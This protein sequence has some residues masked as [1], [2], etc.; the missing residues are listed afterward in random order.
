[1]LKKLNLGGFVM[2]SLFTTVPL[3]VMAPLF[4]AKDANFDLLSTATQTKN[5]ALTT[6]GTWAEFTL[7]NM[8]QKF[9]QEK[10]AWVGS[11]IFKSK[12]ALELKE[13]NLQWVGEN[14]PKLHASLY[15]KKIF[16]KKVIPIQENLVCDGTWN[17][18]K[19]QLIF[20]LNEK[21]VAINK[22]CL[23]LSFPKE[24]ESKIKNG[25]F[26]LAQENP[27]TILELK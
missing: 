6:T 23:V 13:V 11:I 26:L 9:K 4:T 24:F 14:I 10:W 17:K 21:I 5:F 7:K 19:Q 2:L 22:Y 3:L 25:R 16:D 8:Q 20:R 27:L 18:Q 15:Q 1:M 12:Q